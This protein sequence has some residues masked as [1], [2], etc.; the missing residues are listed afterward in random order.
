MTL[1][2]CEFMNQDNVPTRIEVS[3]DANGVKIRVG[4]SINAVELVLDTIEASTLRQ[5][6]SLIEPAY[7][8]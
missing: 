3:Q 6:L 1:V 4:A 7:K 5:M 2:S 8:K